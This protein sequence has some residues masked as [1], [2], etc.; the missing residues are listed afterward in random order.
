[1]GV[2]A[3]LTSLLGVPES[4]KRRCGGACSRTGCSDAR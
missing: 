4:Q 1:M 3:M 2:V